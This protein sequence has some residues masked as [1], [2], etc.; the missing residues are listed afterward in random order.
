MPGTS[1][2]GLEH[3]RRAGL[4]PHRPQGT[5]MTVRL[6]VFATGEPFATLLG[7]TNR[8]YSVAFSPDGRQAAEELV[9]SRR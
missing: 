6:P 7:H 9:D 2:C 8:S 1:A 4:S 5:G 3:R